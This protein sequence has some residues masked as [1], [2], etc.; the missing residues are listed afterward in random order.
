MY[1]GLFFVAIMASMVGLIGWEL[2]QESYGSKH[3]LHDI[4]HE[5]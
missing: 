2:Y 5:D 4:Y 1:I 3:R